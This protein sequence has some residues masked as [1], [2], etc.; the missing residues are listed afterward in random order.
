V[1][2]CVVIA[3]TASLWLLLF[4]DAFEVGHLYVD[5]HE[6]GLN[7]QAG[8]ITTARWLAD[9]G[10]LRSHLLYPA[11][12]DQPRWR[13]YMPGNYYVLAGG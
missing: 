7:D 11:Y 2:D 6:V 1:A 10:E 5:G 3:L 8:Y 12:A 9:T 13:L 4:A